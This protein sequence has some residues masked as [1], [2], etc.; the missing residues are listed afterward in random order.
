M[1]EAN[2]QKK[3]YRRSILI[4]STDEDEF[5]RYASER[6]CDLR[7]RPVAGAPTERTSEIM[8]HLLPLPTPNILRRCCQSATAAVRDSGAVMFHN[9][10]FGTWARVP[11]RRAG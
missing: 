2:G 1:A 8:R 3:V 5:E 9:N 10:N 6:N 7:T 11:Q 4:V